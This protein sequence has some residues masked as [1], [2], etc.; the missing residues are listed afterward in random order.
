MIPCRGAWGLGFL[1]NLLAETLTFPFVSLPCEWAACLPSFSW[2]FQP[3]W[4]NWRRGVCSISLQVMLSVL[5]PVGYSV[6]Y[7]TG[8]EGFTALNSPDGVCTFAAVYL[9]LHWYYSV[10]E[11]IRMNNLELDCIDWCCPCSCPWNFCMSGYWE[12][13]KC[14][15]FKCLFLSVHLKL[16]SFVF[17]SGFGSRSSKCSSY[18]W[19]CRED[20]HP[21][22]L[23]GESL[24]AVCGSTSAWCSSSLWQSWL[25]VPLCWHTAGQAFLPTWLIFIWDEMQDTQR[26]RAVSELLSMAGLAS[27]V[28]FSLQ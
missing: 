6:W 22:D 2:H 3:C 13:K 11:V 4:C 8:C 24:T 19:P 23:P 12:Q 27:V 20:H 1:Q 15:G 16:E 17:P 10:T 9:N 14:G 28:F 26:H 7:Q 21:S 5:C 18:W 25:Q